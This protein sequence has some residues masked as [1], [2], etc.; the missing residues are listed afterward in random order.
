MLIELDSSYMVIGIGCNVMS[1]PEVAVAGANGGR[2][3]THLS[4]YITSPS[5]S[6][7]E[8]SADGS[9]ISNKDEEGQQ[10]CQAL[11]EQIRDSFVAWVYDNG[12]DNPQKLVEECNAMIDYSPQAIRKEYL[13]RARP[14]PASEQLMARSSSE[15]EFE[16]EQDMSSRGDEVLPLRI[17][18]DGTLQVFEF[19]TGTEKML[20]A[21]YLW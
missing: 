6:S 4:K 8:P 1:A 14:V 7:I 12:I 13:S 5:S 3:A 20:V 10:L 9:A 11:A 15:F 16:E 19:K 17:N 18:E 2:P 21:D